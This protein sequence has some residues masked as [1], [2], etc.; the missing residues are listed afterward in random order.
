MVQVWYKF[1]TCS[2]PSCTFKDGYKMEHVLYACPYIFSRISITTTSKYRN[3]I[4]FF[5]AKRS[6]LIK[7][8]GCLSCLWVS[9][10][11]RGW[12]FLKVSL[13]QSALWPWWAPWRVWDC[14]PVCRGC[15]RMWQSPRTEHQTTT[16]LKDVLRYEHGSAT[17]H[18]FRKLWPTNQH[19]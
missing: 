12:L 3:K 17:S 8:S 19:I 5:C 13:Q 1:S 16:H 14:T 2:I 11:G 10:Q 4:W 18:P 7:L 9:E 6:L 15:P